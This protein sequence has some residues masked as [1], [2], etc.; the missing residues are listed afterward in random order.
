MKTAVFKIWGGLAMVLAMLI[1]VA[2]HY[3]G[4]LYNALFFALLVA[5]P[6]A[7]LFKGWSA[8]R[9]RLELGLV[10]RP[11]APEVRRHLLQWLNRC[12]FWLL[13]ALMLDLSLVPIQFEPDEYRGIR[14]L[15]WE[16]AALLVALEFFPRKRVSLWFNLPF[17]FGS[18]FLA[19]QFLRVLGPAP[20]GESVAL[21]APF[22]GEWYVFQGG[23]SALLNHHYLIRK[24]RYALDLCKLNDGRVSH[25]DAA[26]LESYAAYAQELFAPADGKVA[27]V[28]NDRADEPIGGSD[29]DYPVGNHVVIE[30]AP[31]KFVLLAHLMKDSVV[32]RE[33]DPVR[34]GDK[35]ARCGNSGNTSEPHL[36]LQLQNRAT[37]DAP[38][39]RTYPML[40]S[41]VRRTRSGRT[42]LLAQ[43]DLRRNDRVVPAEETR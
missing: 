5:A 10:R 25:G 20:A 16:A 12:L 3:L 1:L 37:F 39:L 13:L 4:L 32:V 30:I 22:R 33:G 27:K 17:A 6:A 28:V 2:V 31:E 40:F 8:L 34:R 14:R 21:G 26:K 43:A 11:F 38:D 24:Q 36:H 23:R 9:R 19:T 18:A 29:E 41:N 35:I 7:V 42:E 15:L